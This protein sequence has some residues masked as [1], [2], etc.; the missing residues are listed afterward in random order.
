MPSLTCQMSIPLFKAQK[1][2]PKELSSEYSV[3]VKLPPA[4]PRLIYKNS[5]DIGWNISKT[6]QPEGDI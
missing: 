6:F 4:H 5:W 1:A 2:Y 3:Q